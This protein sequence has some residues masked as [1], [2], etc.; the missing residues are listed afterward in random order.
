MSK[1]KIAL[2]AALA[3]MSIASPAFAQTQDRYGRVLP[4]QYEGE[5]QVWGSY[6][7][8]PTTNRQRVPQSAPQPDDSDAVM[9]NGKKIGADPDPFIRQEML[10][11]FYSGYPD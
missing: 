3:G 11:H 4:Y 1:S 6:A 2:I 5:T 8:D 9:A 10:R 7:Q